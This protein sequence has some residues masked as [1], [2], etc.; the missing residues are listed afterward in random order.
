MYKNRILSLIT[1]IIVSNFFALHRANA[2]QIVTNVSED[3]I[4]SIGYERLGESKLDYYQ[5]YEN[6]LLYGEFDIPDVI[7]FDTGYMFRFKVSEKSGKGDNRND[8][9][10]HSTYSLYV[11]YGKQEFHLK[12]FPKYKGDAQYFDLG[13]EAMLSA[14]RNDVVFTPNPFFH[15]QLGWTVTSINKIGGKHDTEWANLHMRLGLGIYMQ[16][17]NAIVSTQYGIALYSYDNGIGGLFT[18]EMLFITPTYLSFSLS[19]SFPY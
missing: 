8:I 14:M 13:F 17:H 2:Q 11:N 1:L 18:D 6:E 3:L 10:D 5:S 15:F 19:W 16:I 4:F 12:D 7:R 9:E